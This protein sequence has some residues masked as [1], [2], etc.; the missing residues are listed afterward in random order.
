MNPKVLK[1][2][3]FK[4]LDRVIDLVSCVMLSIE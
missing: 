2:E 1:E 4:H 3:G